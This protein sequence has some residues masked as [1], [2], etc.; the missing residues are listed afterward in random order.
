MKLKIL[1]LAFFRKCGVFFKSPNLQFQV[2]DSF[3]EYFF[4]RFEKRIPLSEKKPPLPAYYLRYV[5]KIIEVFSPII[6]QFQQQFLINQFW[7]PTEI[8][9]NELYWNVCQNWNYKSFLIIAQPYRNLYRYK[10]ENKAVLYITH[11]TSAIY[12]SNLTTEHAYSC[13]FNNQFFYF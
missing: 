7:T 5:L 3:S 13:W 8:V 1:N 4:W 11:D 9:I 6:W 10:K 12:E 2:Q